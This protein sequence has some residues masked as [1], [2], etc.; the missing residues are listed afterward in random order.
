MSFLTRLNN[1]T[2]LVQTSQIVSK[3]KVA[4]P[5]AS[6]NTSSKI[7]NNGK[8]PEDDEPYYEDI[9]SSYETFRQRRVQNEDIEKKR[10][11]LVYQ[12]RKRGISE[13][14]ILLASFANKFLPTM[15]EKQ[16]SEFDQIIS[17]LHNEW[18]LYYWITNAKEIPEELQGN[19]MIYHL[20]SFCMDN[21][22]KT[23]LHHT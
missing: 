16:L 3:V 18:E 8:R 20:K 10:S 1:I 5:L 15:N 23:D 13:N 4:V 11:R 21:K 14:G 7:L 9:K 12:S 22:I 2:R 17:G 19:E 6:F